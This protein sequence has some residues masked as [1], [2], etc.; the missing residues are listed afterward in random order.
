[1]KAVD[2]KTDV[3]AVRNELRTPG[4]ALVNLRSG[5]KW[6]L[7]ERAS[8]LTNRKYDLPLGGGTGLATRRE[9]HRYPAWGDHSTAA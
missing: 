8:M 5:Y 9:T 1:M 3:Q 7:V 2:A 6:K 4:Y